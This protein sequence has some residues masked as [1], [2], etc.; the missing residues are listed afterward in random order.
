VVD[1]LHN[2]PRL[3][4][5][6][7]REIP[8]A[9][10]S[11]LVPAPDLYPRSVVMPLRIFRRIRNLEFSGNCPPGGHLF[12]QLHWI[13]VVQFPCP[14]V[15]AGLLWAHSRVIAQSNSVGPSRWQFERKPRMAYGNVGL[16]RP[17]L[18]QNKRAL[19]LLIFVSN[20]TSRL[21]ARNLQDQVASVG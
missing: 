3:V 6:S 20:Y 13:D 12:L 14:V 21:C 15:V 17:Q 4:P 19:L 10:R 16:E 2:L 8:S 9:F 1:P 18:L 5:N 11:L 7:W